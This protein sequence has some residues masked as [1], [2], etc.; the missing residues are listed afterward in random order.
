MLALQ[1]DTPTHGILEGLGRALQQA[2]R[3]GVTDPTERH[4]G[5][6]FQRGA[7]GFVNPLH[8]EIQ[9]LAAVF[10]HIGGDAAQE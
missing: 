8:K 5:Q 7:G 1:V 10:Q 4:G 2:D 6:L 3:L 9:I